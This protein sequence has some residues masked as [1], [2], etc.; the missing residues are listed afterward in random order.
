MTTEKLLNLMVAKRTDETDDILSVELAHPDGNCLPPFEAGAHIDIH[1]A[2][3]LVRQYS[4]CNSPSDRYRY[5][6]GILRAS[7][8]R[9]GSSSLHAALKPGTRLAV[10]APRSAFRLREGSTFGVLV[11]GGIGITPLMSMAHRLHELGTPFELHYCVRSQAQA[12]FISELAS[13]KFK[14]AVQFHFDD[15]DPKQRFSPAVFAQR[16]AADLYLC[17]PAGFM[18]WI[19]SSAVAAGLATGRIHSERF[20]AAPLA[21]GCTFTVKAARSGVTVNVTDKQT[22]ADALHTVG[23]SVQMSCEQGVCGTCLTRVVEGIPDH[24]DLFQTEAE[25]AANTHIAPCCSRSL[26]GVITLDI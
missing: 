6:L 8:S 25:K 16:T 20:S 17:G 26:S 23:V 19:T 22:I 1:V 2:E 18:E 10:G 9:G 14:S 13:C 7:Q 11:G 21:G 12:A 5:R 24:R 4:I 3:G 15:G